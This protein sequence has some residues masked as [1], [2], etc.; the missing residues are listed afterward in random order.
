MYTKKEV[1][2]AKKAGEFVNSAGFPSEGEA[3]NM[4]TDGNIEI[5]PCL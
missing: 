4:V 3:V 5:C 2:G 1:R